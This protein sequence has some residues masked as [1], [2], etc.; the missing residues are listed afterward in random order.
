MGEPYFGVLRLDLRMASAGNGASAGNNLHFPDSLAI[1]RIDAAALMAEKQ[2]QHGGSTARNRIQMALYNVGGGAPG[3]NATGGVRAQIYILG[4]SNAVGIYYQVF[5]CADSPCSG[6]AS[7]NLL[8]TPTQVGSDINL[9]EGHQ[10]G[11]S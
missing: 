7:I 9:N 2:F 5:Q 8:G 3:T 11:L 6:S 4:D 10:L 1:T